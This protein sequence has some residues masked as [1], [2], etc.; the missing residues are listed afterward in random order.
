MTTDMSMSMDV[1][2]GTTID[3]DMDIPVLPKTPF[4][5]I[6]IICR[7]SV[8]VQSN[9]QHY[10]GL[11][12]QYHAQSDILGCGYRADRPLMQTTKHCNVCEKVRSG[13][14][15]LSKCMGPATQLVTKFPE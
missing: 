4:P 12:C 5:M 8:K 14:A 11:R 13:F 3:M 1:D 9:S 7:I 10:V 15:S 6:Q 2:I